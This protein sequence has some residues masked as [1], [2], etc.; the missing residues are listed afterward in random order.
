MDPGRLGPFVQAKMRIIKSIFRE[1]GGSGLKVIPLDR[2][3]SAEPLK[4]AGCLEGLPL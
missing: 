3:L 1:T 4:D 2:P